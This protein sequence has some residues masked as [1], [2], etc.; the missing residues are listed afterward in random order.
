MRWG[1]NKGRNHSTLHLDHLHPMKTTDGRSFSACSVPQRLHLCRTAQVYCQF[2]SPCCTTTCPTE[3]TSHQEKIKTKSSAE[4]QGPYTA[5]KCHFYPV[6]YL[7]LQFLLCINNCQHLSR[8][9][10][11]RLTDLLALKDSFE[12]PSKSPRAK[13]IV[14]PE[15]TLSETHSTKVFE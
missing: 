3:A 14:T 1:G 6:S 2:R 9:H 5:S 15:S 11:I 12:L 4:L 10:S 8:A 13:S 7:Q